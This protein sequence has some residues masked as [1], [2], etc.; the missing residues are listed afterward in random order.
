[1]SASVRLVSGSVT[2]APIGRVNCGVGKQCESVE[3]ALTIGI[4]QGGNHLIDQ[5]RIEHGVRR[6]D[7][8]A[9]GGETEMHAPTIDV[10]RRARDVAALHEA[11]DGD[12]RGAG[13][14]AE[15]V[16]EVAE[17]ERVD[18]IQM[19]ENLDVLER[20]EVAVD[21]IAGVAPVAGEV[22]PGVV[23]EDLGSGGGETHR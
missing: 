23:A 2:M 4:R 3:C 22:D 12:R 16:C 10:I 8:R 18:R 19:I 6:T 14:H 17:R 21:G 13:R 15:V 5:H 9:G 20:D 11:V 7:A 1:V